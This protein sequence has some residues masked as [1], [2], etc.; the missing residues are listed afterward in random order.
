MYMDK[1]E[2]AHNFLQVIPKAMQIVRKEVRNVSKP[3]LTI[4]QFRVLANVKNGIVHI[5]DIAEHHGVS[6]PA[7]SKLVEVL[8]QKK[9]LSRICDSEDKRAKKLILTPEGKKA[10]LQV[11]KDASNSFSNKLNSIS[12]KEIKQMIKSLELIKEFVEKYK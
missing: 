7:M 5:S 4:A 1:S 2:L 8:V 12:D 11:K 3:N 6:Q 10:F 9:Y